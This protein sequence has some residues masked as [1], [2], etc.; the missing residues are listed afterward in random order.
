MESFPYNESC[1]VLEL[2]LNNCSLLREHSFITNDESVTVIQFV[3]VEYDWISILSTDKFVV[4]LF[5]GSTND[6]HWFEL[7]FESGFGSQP[8]VYAVIPSYVCVFM[9]SILLLNNN[10][11]SYNCLKAA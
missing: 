3:D 11:C 9:C 6:H 4:I 1:I 7:V 8:Y 2:Y 5:V 10:C